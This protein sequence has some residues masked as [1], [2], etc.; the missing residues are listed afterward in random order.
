MLAKATHHTGSTG[1]P[2]NWK[3]EGIL[4]RRLCSTFGH[5]NV[6]HQTSNANLNT[7]QF[8][9][10]NSSEVNLNTLSLDDVQLTYWLCHHRPNPP[11][12]GKPCNFQPNMALDLQVKSMPGPVPRPRRPSGMSQ[13]WV[14]VHQ[15]PWS[16]FVQSSSII[17]PDCSVQTC[18]THNLY[19]FGRTVYRWW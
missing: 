14:V 3:S 5:G 1:W 17:S 7:P 19:L 16:Y 11:A 8:L 13:W 12:L 15:L 4:S 9:L 10:V 2:P 18:K 6:P